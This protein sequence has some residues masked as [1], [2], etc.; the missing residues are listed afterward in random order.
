M[1]D[2]LMKIKS[3]QPTHQGY[4]VIYTGGDKSGCFAY[5]VPVINEAVQS[6]YYLDSR[7]DDYTYYTTHSSGT[8]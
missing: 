3:N 2:I 5:H 1:A 6:G 7:L 8:L 4:S